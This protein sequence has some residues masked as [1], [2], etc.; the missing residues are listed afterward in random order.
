MSENEILYAVR[1]VLDK[2]HDNQARE[3]ALEQHG[4]S[5]AFWTSVAE[6]GWFALV[7]PESAE[8]FGLPVH[9]LVPIFQLLGQRLVPG[10]WL[11]QMLLPGLLL[12]HLEPDSAA[13]QSV[14]PALSGERRLALLDG[15][16]THTWAG[17]M[18]TPQVQGQTLTGGSQIVRSAAEADA[19]VVV[20][21][22][23]EPRLLLVDAPHEALTL[24]PAQ[25]SDPCVS[26]AA[27]RFADLPLAQATIL[28]EGP[29][30]AEAI[31]LLRSWSR[32]LISAELSGISR[33]MLDMSVEYVGQRE[34]FGRPVATFQAVKHIAAQMA[35]DVVTLESFCQ[36]VATDAADQDVNELETA[37]LAL[38]QIA[39]ETGRS[40]TESALQLHGGIGFTYEH[41]LHWYYKRALALRSVYG[42]ER[43]SAIRLGQLRLAAAAQH[44]P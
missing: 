3:A 30:A 25:S 35:R 23:D 2:E 41:A 16:I 18:G 39:S 43:E 5:E 7:A 36:A 42:D 14:A 9:E 8:G 38:K 12:T 31:S 40:V 28:L 29:A 15:G 11:E 32:I 37:A 44:T 33:A 17:L 27:V 13:A 10:S 4:P 26:V 22:G 19:F 20:A 34:Q 6:Q 1:Q 24:E 21:E